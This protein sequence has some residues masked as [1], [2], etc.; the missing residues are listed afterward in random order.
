VLLLFGCLFVVLGVRG[1]E[2]EKKLEEGN[3]WEKRD[4]VEESEGTA[5]RGGVEPKRIT[6]KQQRDEDRCTSRLDSV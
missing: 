1:R 5:W 6:Q 2:E 3:T 4:G